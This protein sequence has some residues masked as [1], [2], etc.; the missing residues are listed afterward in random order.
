MNVQCPH[1]RNPIEVVTLTAREEIGCPSC[2]SQFRLET[3]ATTGW[4]QSAGQKLG[5]FEVL[6][7]VGQGAFGT[8]YKARD[9]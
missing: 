1:C 4:D 3:Q 7:T 9:P 8:V 2:G 5:R 6:D